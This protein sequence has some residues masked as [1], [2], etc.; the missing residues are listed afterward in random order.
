MRGKMITF[1]LVGAAAAALPA[2]CGHDGSR[3]T[4]AATSSQPN[5]TKPLTGVAEPLAGWDGLPNASRAGAVTFGGQPTE[6]ALER[7][8]AEGGTLVVDN[9]THEGSDKADFDEQAAAERLGM[10]YLHIPMTGSS[11]TRE[12]VDRF[13]EAMEQAD[14]PVLAHCRSA[15]RT[16]GLWA[17]YLALYRGW[18]V[19]KA[20]EAGRAAGMRAPS[21]EESARRLIGG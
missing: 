1:V 21:V 13:A 9:R 17:A 3:E 10:T 4:R 7:F 20:I 16:G 11:L 12:D 6:A 19:E 5:A 2:G 14:G 15:N 8:A 18:D